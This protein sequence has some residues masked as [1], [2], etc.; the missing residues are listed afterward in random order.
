MQR[1][2]VT[3]AKGFIG[4]HLVAHLKTQEP[5]AEVIAAGREHDLTVPAACDELFRNAG[6]L[7]YVFHLADVSGNARWSAENA[8]TQFFLNAKIS[9]NVLESVSRH[10]RQARLVGFS[11]VWAYP[12]SVNVARESSYWAGPVQD[13]IQHYGVGKKF[14]GSG[15]KA[16]KQQLGMKGTMLVMGSVYGPG[17]RSDHLI[18][19]LIQRMKQNPDEVEVWGSGAQLRDFIYIEDQIKA[20]DLHKDYEGD[21]LNVS[22]G[23]PHS[24]RDVVETLV[25]LLPYSG[26]VVYRAEQGRQDDER[27]IDMTLAQQ[28]TGWPGKYRLRTLEEGLSLTLKE[29]S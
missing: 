10:Q 22:A 11:S 6:P 25:R 12:A 5:Q 1:Y 7:D 9:L 3:G 17:D 19:S 4:R 16:C 8:A 21:L 24:V 29:P 15:L 14:L 13:A 2:L 23:K 28:T 18:P 27:R 20:I 26:R